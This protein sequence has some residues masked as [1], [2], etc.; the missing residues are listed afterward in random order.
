M[1]YLLFAGDD[2]YPA[3]GAGDLEGIFAT[4]EDAIAAHDPRKYSYS[5]GWAH[6]LNLETMKIEK[7]FLSCRWVDVKDKTLG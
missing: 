2:Y 3:G 1:A 5:G 4:A 6:I 7:D